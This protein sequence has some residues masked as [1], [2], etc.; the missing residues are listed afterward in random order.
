MSKGVAKSSES[1]RERIIRAAYTCFER[2]SVAK[3]SI[4]DIL[5]EAKLSRPTIYKY[6]SG[7]EAIF[8]EICVIES[9]KLNAEVRSRINRKKAFADTFTEVILLIVR[10]A[11]A[12]PYLRAGVE[13]AKFASH[14]TAKDSVLHDSYR[15]LWGNFLKRAAE[16]GE[17]ASDISVEE[18]ISWIGSSEAM[19]MMRVDAVELSDDE[20][21]RIIRRFVVQPLLPQSEKD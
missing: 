2:F 1:H 8:Q 3:T 21:R 20:L 7:K 4:E 6:F 19:L 18:I 14:A 16:R 15:E 12:N 11:M 13:D 5:T 9:Q 10:L 17:L